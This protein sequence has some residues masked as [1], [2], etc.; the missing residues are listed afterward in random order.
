MV[1]RGKERR[2]RSGADALSPRLYFTETGRNR[3]GL[4]FTVAL[5]TVPIIIVLLFSLSNPAFVTLR[6][7][8]YVLIFEINILHTFQALFSIR[9]V[10]FLAKKTQSFHSRGF[11]ISSGD[12]DKIGVI[13]NRKMF[14]TLSLLLILSIVCLT[15]TCGSTPRRLNYFLV[16]NIFV[17]NI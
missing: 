3:I 9:T 10:Y 7:E 15:H 11:R 4:N 16:G 5:K 13:S 6:R 1:R 8:K 17:A 14:A 2:S 12:S